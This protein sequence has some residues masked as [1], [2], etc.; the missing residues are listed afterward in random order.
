MG[1]GLPWQCK[2]LLAGS[3]YVA[4]YHAANS[5][6]QQVT[7][8]PQ[9]QNLLLLLLPRTQ[10]AALA[11]SRDKATPACSNIHAGHPTAHVKD[12]SQQATALPRPQTSPHLQAPWSWSSTR[13]GLLPAGPCPKP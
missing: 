9:S 5:D 8:L 2:K 10:V 6:F 3:L 13:Q 11:A 1:A 4:P 12:Q 7:T